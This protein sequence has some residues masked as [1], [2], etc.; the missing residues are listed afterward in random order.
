MR[1]VFIFTFNLVLYSSCVSQ[2]PKVGG[3][4]FYHVGRIDNL[5]SFI[6]FTSAELRTDSLYKNSDRKMDSI[7][8]GYEK[9]IANKNSDTAKFLT[10]AF[11]SLRSDFSSNRARIFISGVR[12]GKAEKIDPVA[13]EGLPAVC[14]CYQDKDIISV[15]FAFGFFGG[16]AV[17]QQIVGSLFHTKVYVVTRHA[18][19]YKAS[20][21]DTAFRSELEIEPLK[22]NMTLLTKPSMN[23]GE[24][25]TGFVTFQ[26]KPYFENAGQGNVDSVSINV[27]YFFTCKTRQTLTAISRGF[28]KYWPRPS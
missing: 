19:I 26:S 12:N 1:T 7:S 9:K 11:A 27:R 24:Q 4:S 25:L 20:L 16:F 10:D 23:I 8:Q 17:R 5:E 2:L 6:K 14:N 3:Y 13:A 22:Q 15:E 21:L 28:M 18:D